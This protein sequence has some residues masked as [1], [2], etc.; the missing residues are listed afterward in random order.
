MDVTGP[1]RELHAR[2]RRLGDMT[3][4]TSVQIS[5]VVGPPTSISSM[6]NGQTLLQWQA[7]GCHMALLFDA[8]SRFIRITHEYVNTQPAPSGCA[9]TVGV[10][11]GILIAIGMIVS[12]LH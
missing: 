4:L 8:E 9:T 2:F 3:G 11:L 12:A 6:A 5:M 1:G 7:T 10:L